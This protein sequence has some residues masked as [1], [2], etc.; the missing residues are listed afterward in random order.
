MSVSHTLYIAS[1]SPRRH[2]ILKGLGYNL[3][4]VNSEI[5]E[6]QLSNE[7]ASEYVQRLALE[8]CR[9]GVQQ[10]LNQYQQ[11][12]LKYPLLTADTTVA[13]HNQLLGKPTSVDEAKTMLRALSGTDHQVYTAVCI[14]F[15]GEYYPLLQTSHVTFKE[16]SDKDIDAY[17]ATGEP[18]DKAGAY[19]IQ[20]VGGTFV[21]HLNGSFTG[22]MGLPIYET[23]QQLAK[24]GFSA[25][26]N[27]SSES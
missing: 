7:G 9:H 21:T 11:D 8:K 5:D 23:S 12:Y 25:L 4:I 6:S 14:Y 15:A 10:A 2:Q 20:G 18:M 17:I 27:L 26:Q 1:A 24:F 3:L 13:I 16:L 22:V 19:G